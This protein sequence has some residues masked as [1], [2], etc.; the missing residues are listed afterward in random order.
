MYSRTQNG[1]QGLMGTDCIGLISE[2]FGSVR[3]IYDPVNLVL[4]QNAVS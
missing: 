1:S 4:G 2:E 3:K